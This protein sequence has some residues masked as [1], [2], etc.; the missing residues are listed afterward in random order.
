MFGTSVADAMP[1]LLNIR[2]Q[3][4]SAFPAASVRFGFSSAIIR[5]IWHERAR[6]RGYRAVHPEI[7]EDVYGVGAPAEVVEELVEQGYKGIVVQPVYMTP[8]EE[9][10]GLIDAISSC[11]DD[12]L[13][14]S[15]RLVVGRPALGIFENGPSAQDLSTAARALAAD[16]GYARSK[17]AA[18]LYMGHGSKQLPQVTDA[19]YLAFAEA[20]TGFF[21]ETSVLVATVEDGALGLDTAFALLRQRGVSRLVLKPF[22]VVAGDHVRRDMIDPEQRGWKTRLE[23]EGFTVEPVV[24][25]LGEQDAFANIFVRHAADAAAGAGIQLS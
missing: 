7:P 15:R 1:G 17:N 4:V 3:M 6:D 23:K 14:V 9:Y 25:G 8:G 5:R 21:P 10:C 13:N 12:A 11:R 24:K 22:M 18:L 19:V 2:A 20:M 16:V